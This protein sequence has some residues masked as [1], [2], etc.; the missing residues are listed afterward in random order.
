VLGNKRR[1]NVRYLKGVVFLISIIFGVSRGEILVYTNFENNDLSGWIAHPGGGEISI[2]EDPPYSPGDTACFRRSTHGIYSLGIRTQD[3]FYPTYVVHPFPNLTGGEEYLVEFYINIPQDSVIGSNFYIY[4]AWRNNGN[5][6]DI[7]I[8][9]T[10]YNSSLY[11]IMVQDANGSYSLPLTLYADTL[12]HPQ[13]WYRFQIYKKN[14][15]V[16]LYID[17]RYYGNFISMS[18][19]QPPDSVGIGTFNNGVGEILFDDFFVTTPPTGDHPRL[20]FSQ[21][22]IPSLQARRFD[23]DPGVLGISYKTLWDTIEARATRLLDQDTMYIN[24]YIWEY[25]FHYPP[26]TWG[27][28]LIQV[29]YPQWIQYLSFVAAVTGDTLYANKAKEILLAAGSWINWEEFL[30]HPLALYAQTA[31]AH[32]TINIALGYD[33]LYNFLTP[34]ERMS[35]QNALIT[36]G[37]EQI[38]LALT[39]G[40]QADP[41]YASNKQIVPAIA[42]GLAILSLDVGTMYDSYLDRA[43]EIINSFL[44]DPYE[45]YDQQRGCTRENIFYGGYTLLHLTAFSE[46]LKRGGYDDFYAEIINHMK[47]RISCLIPGGL[48]YIPFGDSSVEMDLDYAYKLASEY[49][50][51][52]YQWYIYENRNYT[53]DYGLG[54]GGDYFFFAGFLW[55]DKDLGIFPPDSA[56][57][58]LAELYRTTGWAILRTGWGEDDILFGITSRDNGPYHSQ[59]DNN[60]IVLGYRGEW[61]IGENNDLYYTRTTEDHNTLLIDSTLGQVYNQNAFNVGRIETLIVD[62]NFAFVVAKAE[63]SYKEA[64]VYP[65]ETFRREALLLFPYKLL[66]LQDF[67]KTNGSPH[68]LFWHFH[69]YGDLQIDSSSFSISFN[70]YRIISQWLGDGIGVT[71]QFFNEDT[72]LFK[73]IIFSTADSVDEAHL[74]LTFI[75]LLDPFPEVKLDK[76]DSF[77]RIEINEWNIIGSRKG[78]N[79]DYVTFYLDSTS[80]VNKLLFLNLSPNSTYYLILENDTGDFKFNSFTTSQEGIFEI[81]LPYS[82]HNQRV[83]LFQP[84]YFK[85]S[86]YLTAFNNG[87]KLLAGSGKIF[88]CY[89]LGDYIA[90]RISEDNGLSWSEKLLTSG[91]YPALV[92]DNGDT[93]RMTYIKGNRLFFSTMIGDSLLDKRAIYSSDSSTVLYSPSMV[94]SFDTIYIAFTE[95]NT[96]TN[97]WSLLMGKFYK[98]TGGTAI[99][100]TIDRSSPP[101]NEL[102]L[103][104]LVSIDADTDGKVHLLW[105]HPIDMDNYYLLYGIYGDSVV[106]ETLVY[107]ENIKEPFIRFVDGSLHALWVQ[108]DSLLYTKRNFPDTWKPYQYIAENI[109][110]ISSPFMIEDGSI[111]FSGSPSPYPKENLIYWI[112]PL[113][114]G[115]STPQNITPFL[116]NSFFPQGIL[117][118]EQNNVLLTVWTYCFGD[119]YD[120]GNIIISIPNDIGGGVMEMGSEILTSVTLRYPNP[121]DEHSYLYLSVP[122][123]SRVSLKLYDVSGR[124]VKEIYNG[125]LKRGGH[126]FFVSLERSGV[127]FIQLTVEGK[128]ETYKWIYLRE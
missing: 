122:S 119:Y 114:S 13:N 118:N 128:S 61:Y 45:S 74:L 29:Y 124:L 101:L 18:G 120:V 37:I 108:N 53:F 59:P 44:Q 70:N 57:Y 50:D 104:S 78:E 4:R 46:A 76:R 66:I 126:N 1:F 56:G 73:R 27:G 117:L 82:L 33:F 86:P 7:A 40:I 42:M 105:S 100:N 30:L 47:W 10:G 112:Y 24:G 23:N 116:F 92:V 6:A 91:Y 67:V 99:W 127:Y 95:F 79:L 111:L 94:M 84:S 102:N 69:T 55:M 93:L 22:E 68:R 12:I 97:I 21:A 107:M 41:P 63:S 17:G 83:T 113:G 26:P 60:S 14:Q 31:N 77:W 9:I 90:L 65:L 28:I 51:P 3:P 35:I 48:K 5:L 96:S 52:V 121:G 19:V 81:D 123:D 85:N 110:N 87:K 11:W 75:P 98:N 20:L 62:H 80:I 8:S 36:H 58:P 72:L 39:V 43:L 16:K 125:I 25:P 49:Q 109:V 34:F 32:I 89:T 103:N 64:N 115:F 88:L 54:I 106:A 38:Y 71:T 2:L 15:N